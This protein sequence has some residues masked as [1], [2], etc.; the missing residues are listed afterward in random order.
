MTLGDNPRAFKKV[1]IKGPMTNYPTCSKVL[2][3]RHT[4]TC[5]VCSRESHDVPRCVNLDNTGTMEQ[6][7]NIP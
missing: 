2:A 3:E 6:A 5:H 4:G 7:W 1:S